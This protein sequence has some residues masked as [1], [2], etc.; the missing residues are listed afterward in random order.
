MRSMRI[1]L[2][3]AAIALAVSGG[4]QVAAQELRDE[5]GPAERGANPI[6]PANPI[7]RRTLSVTPTYP[8]EAAAIDASARVRLRITIDEIGRVAEIRPVNL[9]LLVFPGTPADARALQAAAAALTAAAAD[10]VRQWQ[11]DSP[12]DPP[13]SFN[14]TIQFAPG[15]EPHFGPGGEPARVSQDRN[16]SVG[17]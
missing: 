3:S 6:A 15:V 4:R 9:P 13:I 8:P 2:F 11:Y 16:T 5:P 10:A 1:A 12:A 7:P 14:V 17:P